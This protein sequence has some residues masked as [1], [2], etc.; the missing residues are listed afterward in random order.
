MVKTLTFL[1][2]L[3]IIA[4]SAA[5]AY[6]Q[7]PAAPAGKWEAEIKKFEEAD[8]QH[9]PARGAVLFIGSSS[10]ALWKDLAEDFPSTRVLNRGFG[11]SE[12]ADSTY[13]V[14]RI[15]V[16]YRPR[17]IVLYAGDNDLANGK[18]PQQVFEDYRAF[19]GRVRRYLP[20][21]RIAFISIKPSPARA[22]LIQ[23]MKATNEMIRDYASRHR[24]LIYIDVFT[25]MVGADGRPRGE[26][27]GQDGLHMNREGYS[28]WRAVITP[29]IR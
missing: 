22:S 1:K 16:P 28:L 18:T 7:H 19:V 11:G 17:M 24:G 2:V 29:Y 6:A 5:W 14:G 26:L 21:V 8:R 25:S 13:Y 27:F 15:V 10:I 3:T 23:K 9:P 12:I 20:Q 4:A